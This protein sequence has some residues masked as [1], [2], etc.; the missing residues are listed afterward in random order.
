MATDCAALA[1]HPGGDLLWD[2]TAGLLRRTFDS[3]DQQLHDS[4]I[5]SEVSGT[6]GVA[7]LLQGDKIWTANV[8]DSRAVIGRKR[9]GGAKGVYAVQGLTD[10]QKPDTPEEQA[11]RCAPHP[12]SHCHPPP[13]TT[14]HHHP[15][16][17]TPLGCALEEQAPPP[18]HPTL[19]RHLRTI[20]PPGAYPRGGRLRLT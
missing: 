11:R 20:A 16:P 7:V 19:T 4:S 10:D 13:P 6:T 9:K 8:G 15:P 17:P 2:D 18:P 5:A 12:H 14:T 1:T 3:A